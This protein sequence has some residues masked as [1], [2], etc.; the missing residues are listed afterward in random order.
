MFMWT[1]L[2][3]KYLVALPLLQLILLTVP[4]S[5]AQIR[6]Q[7]L[8]LDPPPLINKLFSLILQEERHKSINSGGIDSTNPSLPFAVPNTTTRN[9]AYTEK[10]NYGTGQRKNRPFCIH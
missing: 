9:P 5:F 6:G 10:Q 1:T 3:S 7:I 4:S 2:F 8:L